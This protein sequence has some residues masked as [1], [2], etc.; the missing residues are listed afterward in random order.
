MPRDEESHP[1]PPDRTPVLI[2]GGGPAG[3]ATAV[4]LA[5]HGVAST[6]VETRPAVSWLR[7]GP[8]RPRPA[9]WS[10]CAA[11]VWPTRSASGPRWR[12]RGP[13]KWS[14]APPCSGPR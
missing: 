12:R 9:P 3:L 13:T 6:V 2:V 10:T 1:P 4:E 5:A 8:R 11:G 7:P 14:S